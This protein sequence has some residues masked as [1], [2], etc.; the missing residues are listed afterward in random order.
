MVASGAPDDRL[1]LTPRE[2]SHRLV[3]VDSAGRAD[4]ITFRVR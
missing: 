2:G 1:F 4:S 3:V